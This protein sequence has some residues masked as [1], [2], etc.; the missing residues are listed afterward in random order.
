VLLLYVIGFVAGLVAGISPC[1]LP[2]LPVVL[3]AGATVP[4]TPDTTLPE[5]DGAGETGETGDGTGK[6]ATTERSGSVR[7]VGRT[8]GPTTVVPRSRSY[9]A[10]A[11]VAGLVISFS[12]FTLVGSSLLSALGLPQDFLRDAG[13]VVLGLVAAGLIVPALGHLL[14]RPFARLARR[15][16]TGTTGGFV[17]GL[18][19]GVLFVPCAGPVL[20]A[21]TVVGATHRV[22]F[23]A[24]VLTVDFALGASVPLLVF[25]LAGQRVAERVAGFRSRAALARQIGGV[26][27]LAMTL[28]IAFNVT[29]GLQR[30]VPGYTSVLQRHIEGGSYAKKQLAS[31]TG[32]KSSGG[33]LADCASGL[34]SLEN[35]GPAP[36]F[37]GITAWRNTPG[38]RPLSLASLKGKVVLVDFWTY[39]CIN[40]QRS[41]PHV[42][43][44]YARYHADG[45]EVVGVHTPEFAF[46]HVVSNV[47]QASRQ[48]GVVYPVAVDDGYTTWNAYQ[49]QY[50]PAEYLIDATGE[51]RHAEFGEGDYGGTESLIRTLL[52]DANPKVKLPGRTDVPDQTPMTALTP[53]SYLGYSHDLPNFDGTSI[54]PDQPAQYKFPGSLPPDYLAFDGTWTVGK[55]MATA[56]AGARLELAF[57][58]SHVYLVLGGTGTVKAT[59]GTHNQTIDV[60]G[61]PRLYT[62]VSSPTFESATL[63]LSVS[64]GVDAYDFTFG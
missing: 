18:G 60:S 12:I 15:Q 56:G 22:G 26:V 20:A 49:N 41:L 11:V 48:L 30:V 14:E 23:R 40:C 57:Q 47:T 51:I 35:C 36:N 5:A 62:L 29:D 1:I 3:V 63:V 10:Y 38:D 55:E 9:R 24:V 45:F 32:A 31:L 8:S 27:L 17:L 39:S 19:L 50:W 6:S 25:A 34:S 37:Q 54:T 16:P 42:E 46:E 44:W 43:S 33:K 53:E 7:V 13:L 2:V 21:I 59:V 58:A 61:I 4:T 64:P 28:L 52:V